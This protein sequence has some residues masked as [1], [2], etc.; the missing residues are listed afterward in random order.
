MQCQKVFYTVYIV[1]YPLSVL[2]EVA[3]R[4]KKKHAPAKPEPEDDMS[5]R[6]LA[7]TLA[8]QGSRYRKHANFGC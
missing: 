8:F 4:P 3:T 7:R 5:R 6:A 2:F 1:A